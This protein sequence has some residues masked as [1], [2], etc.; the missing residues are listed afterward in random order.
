MIR[1]EDTLRSF[2][3]TLTKSFAVLPTGLAIFDREGQLALFNPALIDMTGLDAA[4]L[5]RRPRMTDFF[6][7]LR[8]L[9]KLPEPR[10][11]K[12]WRDDLMTHPFQIENGHILRCQNTL[13]S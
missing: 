5:S 9:Q 13:K 1:A 8:D 11:Y 7:A 12:A 2:I 10:D 3:Q 4:F 6:D